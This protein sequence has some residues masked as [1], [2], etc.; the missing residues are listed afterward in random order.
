MK[1]A[2]V[3]L[4]GGDGFIGTA[5][6]QRLRRDDIPVHVVGRHAHG[7]LETLLP[8]CGTVIHLASATTPGSSADMPDLELDN[9]AL[10]SHLLALMKDQPDTHLI[11]FSSGGTVYGNPT[12]IPVDED[13]PLAPLSNYAAGKISQEALC[14]AFREKGHAISILRPSNAYGPGQK[15]KR[16]F[17]LVRTMLGHAHTGT[18]MEIWGDG[19]TVRDFIY[20]DD[21]VEACAR[22]I[23]LPADSGTYNLGSGLGFSINQ[24]HRI[25]EAVSG[26][27]L[28][29]TY[30]PGRGIDVRCVVLDSSRLNGRLQ[31]NSRVD[32]RTGVT[33]TWD[34]M[35]AP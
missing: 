19:E 31:W 26:K 20:I 27:E 23:G 9:L 4:L 8:G 1:R 2:A 14:Q 5:V 35:Q 18:T 29:L 33:Q 21:I 12:R 10:T 3:L 34:W 6:A 28:R 30:Q 7:L 25:V 15:L 22:L 11:F 13:A 24:V 32:L 16:G 17:G